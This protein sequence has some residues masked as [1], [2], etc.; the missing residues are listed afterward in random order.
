[1]ATYLSSLFSLETNNTLAVQLIHD[2]YFCGL[3]LLCGVDAEPRDEIGRK[4]M[5]NLW[6][7]AVGTR[8]LSVTASQW[9]VFV[10]ERR[11]LTLGRL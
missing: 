4:Y 1:M 2:I 11:A 5:R 6:L 10:N 8:K 3:S 7:A 9:T